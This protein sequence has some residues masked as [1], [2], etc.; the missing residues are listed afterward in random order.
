[1]SR[2]EVEILVGWSS[3]GVGIPIGKVVEEHILFNGLSELLLL[4]EDEVE[5][6]TRVDEGEDKVTE[7]GEETGEGR[8]AGLARDV[9]VG[10]WGIGIGT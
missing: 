2:G 6:C 9:V 7:E 5:E 4:I 10:E 1:M 3:T 8:E